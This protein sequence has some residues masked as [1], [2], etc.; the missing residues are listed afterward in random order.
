MTLEE[1]DEQ[2]N[3]RPESRSNISGKSHSDHDAFCARKFVLVRSIW[4]AIL[5]SMSAAAIPP[6]SNPL[7]GM[8]GIHGRSAS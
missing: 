5:F 2:Q 3:C 1:N 4:A 6:I 7:I 8:D